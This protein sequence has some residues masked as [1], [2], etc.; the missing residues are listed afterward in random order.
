MDGWK[1]WIWVIIL[2]YL[3]GYYFPGLAAATVG[4]LKPASR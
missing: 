2:G 4:K 1:H 3:L